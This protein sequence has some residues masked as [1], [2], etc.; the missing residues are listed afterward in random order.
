MNP[1]FQSKTYHE[2]II[3]PDIQPQN[4]KLRKNHPQSVKLGVYITQK[5]PGLD[6]FRFP[7]W[8]K[9]FLYGIF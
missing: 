9:A 6:S 1:R 8:C 2:I 4:L 3:F 7:F 5:F